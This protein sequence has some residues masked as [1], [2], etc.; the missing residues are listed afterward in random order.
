MERDY[1]DREGANKEQEEAGSTMSERRRG[2]PR[3]EPDSAVRGTCS[4]LDHLLLPAL[5]KFTTETD[6]DDAPL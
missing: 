5:I 2:R 3:V 1:T 6:C 4:R